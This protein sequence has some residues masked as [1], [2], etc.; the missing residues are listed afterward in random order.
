MSSRQRPQDVALPGVVD[1][2]PVLPKQADLESDLPQPVPDQTMKVLGRHSS[3]EP[4]GNA[5]ESAQFSKVFKDK[6]WLYRLK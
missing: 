6:A 4:S 1:V 5:S 3:P 2:P